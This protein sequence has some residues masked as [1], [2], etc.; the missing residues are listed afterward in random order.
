MNSD[1]VCGLVYESNKRV[2][3][4]VESVNKELEELLLSNKFEEEFRELGLDKKMLNVSIVTMLTMSM[5]M[6]MIDFSVF[7]RTSL[8]I[9]FRV[10]FSGIVLLLVGMVNVWSLKSRTTKIMAW[11][12]GKIGPLLQEE[13]DLINK[14][15]L[16]M[17]WVHEKTGM[18]LV[19]K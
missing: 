5:F 3:K 1:E 12:S 2:E 10:C 7:S 8:P 15:G 16:E 17:M 19:C 18:R 13:T 11:K 6:F 14:Q 9:V 4:L